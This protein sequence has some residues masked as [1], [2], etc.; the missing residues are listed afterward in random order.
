MDARSPLRAF[1]LAA[2]LAAASAAPAADNPARAP[3][4]EGAAAHPD[5][6]PLTLDAAVELV[7]HRFDA[8]VVR[9]EETKEGEEVYYRIRLLAEDG[10]VFT[11]R[12]SARTGRVE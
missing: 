3:P 7:K 9:A 4:P 1:A 11:V 6:A 12:V 2:L 5:G 10:R 8:R